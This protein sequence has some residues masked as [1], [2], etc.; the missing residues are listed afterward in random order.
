MLSL[1]QRKLVWADPGRETSLS[2][3]TP[4]RA[5]LAYPPGANRVMVLAS[6][7]CQGPYARRNLI[8][9]PNFESNHSRLKVYDFGFQSH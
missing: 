6:A 1:K 8:L 7:L 4:E 2:V 3:S 5:G 9:K